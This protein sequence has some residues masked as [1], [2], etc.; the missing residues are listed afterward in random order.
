[1]L[2]ADGARFRDAIA[3]RATDV[4]S[5]FQWTVGIW[6]RPRNAPHDY[7]HPA[8][9]IDAAVSAVFD[10]FEVWRLYADDQ[11]IAHLMA[12]WQGRWGDD[13]VMRWLTNR[14][15]PIAWAVRN[16]TEALGASYAAVQRG[17][18]PELSHDGD[19]V[20]E[21]HIRNARK[22]KLTVRDEE[23]SLMYTI[24]K[25]RRNSPNKIDSAMADVL[26]WEARRDA[27]AAGARRSRRAV[28]FI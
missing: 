4:E 14:D 5:G 19:P 23:G 2:G 7:E 20:A 22:R 21:R 3:V 11:H 24:A 17:D 8:T 13:R 6:E 16:F 27:V 1:V 26:S 10:R 25:D 28:V 15:R 18:R 9:D 12:L